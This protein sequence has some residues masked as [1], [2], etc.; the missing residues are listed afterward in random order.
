MKKLKFII[1]DHELCT[2][3]HKYWKHKTEHGYCKDCSCR[4]FEYFNLLKRL[5]V[6]YG[7]K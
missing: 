1:E 2:C 4:Q 3:K 6:G 7:R 5:K